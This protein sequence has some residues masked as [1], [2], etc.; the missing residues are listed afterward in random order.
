MTLSGGRADTYQVLA[1][2]VFGTS[3]ELHF[4]QG[5]IS[6]HSKFEEAAGQQVGKW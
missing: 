1:K 3:V 6:T 2:Q 4:I 5:T